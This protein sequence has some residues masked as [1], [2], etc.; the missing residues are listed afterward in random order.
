MV[1][2]AGALESKRLSQIPIT[3]PIKIN[4]VGQ[5]GTYQTIARYNQE[6]S[7]VSVYLGR[8]AE[9][10]RSVW[11]F[12][13]DG[14]LGEFSGDR[15]SLT[16]PCR[17]RVLSEGSENGRRWQV[18][19]AVQGGPLVDI[20][21]A[22]SNCS[23]ESV[24]PCFLELITELDHAIDDQTLPQQ[25]SLNQVWTN[26]SGHLKLLDRPLTLPSQKMLGKVHSNPDPAKRAADLFSELLAVYSEQHS[27]PIHVIEF[28]NEFEARSRVA[29]PGEK[30][31]FA[32]AARQ[33]AEFADRPS[34][35]N[36]D[37]R[38]GLLAVAFGSEF[39]IYAASVF[40][41]GFL[42]ISLSVPSPLQLGVVTFAAV[43]AL[44]FAMGFV[45]NGGLAMKLSGIQ[46]CRR[47]T[48]LTASRF[49]CGIRNL[50]AWI[51]FIDLLVSL[52]VVIQISLFS[53]EAGDAV[54]DA[55]GKSIVIS[56]NS[57]GAAKSVFLLLGTLPAL[58]LIFFG[59]VWALISPP[60]G[61]PDL[62]A[63]TKLIRK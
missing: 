46:V 18:T 59:V 60:R 55:L 47:R 57:V 22:L 5:F 10:A 19:E 3:A 9:L 17:L 48:N 24:R 23:W 51:L 25:L 53:V 50:V 41:V 30:E 20:I 43:A 40:M 1:R 42:M 29:G 35:W 39:P 13:K 62:V 52:L 31:H 49:R 61:L 27:V 7:P 8:D 34:N 12:H 6:S 38:L 54:V 14:A 2:L 33:L 26:H 32:W 4:Q 36:W 45:L 11:V 63:G 37:D 16:R 44:A 28:R 56:G 58:F 21:T 15:K